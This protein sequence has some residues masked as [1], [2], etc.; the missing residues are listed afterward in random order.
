MAKALIA[1]DLQN[2]FYEEG[3]L[4]VPNAFEI[5]QKVNQLIKGEIFFG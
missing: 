2:D 5:N 4:A 3:A 1:V